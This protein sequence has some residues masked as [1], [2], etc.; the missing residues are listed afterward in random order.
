M[1]ERTFE[2]SDAKS[3]KFW[4]VD[5]RGTDVVTKY[6][7]IGTDG[8]ST[9]KSHASVEA[10]QKTFDKLVNEKL[11]KGYVETTGGAAAGSSDSTQ[12]GQ[13]LAPN[14]FQTTRNAEDIGEMTTFIGKRVV[15]FKSLKSLR[16]GDKHVYRVRSGWDD[17]PGTFEK[18]LNEFLDSDAAARA[19]GLIIGY[20][21]ID[22]P[23]PIEPVI[24]ILVKRQDRLPELVALFLGDIGQEESEISWIQQGD[25][26]PLLAAFPKLEMLRVRGSEGLAFKK[27]KHDSLAALGVEAGGLGADVV[28][29]LCKAKFP[30]L[31]HL[32]LWL[33]TDEYGGDCQINDLQPILA[34]KLFPKLNYLG[35]RNAQIAD[36]IAGV[37]V[38]SPIA[39]QIE[40]LDL[41][42]GTLSDEGGNA[43]LDLPQDGNLKRLDL[44]YHFMSPAVTKKLSKLP[45]TVNT[46]G[47]QEPDDWG[48]GE[49]MRYVAIAE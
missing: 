33:G 19:Q 17:E 20:W 11:K 3:H 38:N 6:G 41:S 37:I 2:F 12:P 1:A 30:Q 39:K 47:V 13:V 5:L 32:E 36:E 22:V 4:N 24:K 14:M 18:R 42:L 35:L 15:D 48:D 10:A 9:V 29:Q 25:V 23:D 45:F 49:L 26:S 40:T 46:S 34:G 44:H 43:L 31:E 8:Q 7:R 21:S 28:R 16:K 27:P